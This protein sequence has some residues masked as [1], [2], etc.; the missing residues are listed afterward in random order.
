MLK[1]Q[2]QRFRPSFSTVCLHWE[3]GRLS[4]I[5][6]VAEISIQKYI[7]F[8]VHFQQ[9]VLSYAPIFKLEV[10][11][12][13]SA[14]FQGHCFKENKSMGSKSISIKFSEYFVRRNPIIEIS[15][16]VNVVP[17]TVH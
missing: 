9:N 12:A 1:L 13:G 11:L 14:I 3:T 15:Y 17:L 6:E 4:G 5:N 10:L 8:K 2:S 16:Q 7:I